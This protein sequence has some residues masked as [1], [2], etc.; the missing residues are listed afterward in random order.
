MK[1]FH[2]LAINPG[3]TSTKVA[4]FKND[5]CLFEFK[6]NH[7][8]QEL[9][10]YDSIWEQYNFR[11]EAISKAL[12]EQNGFS[13]DQLDA[14]VGRGGLINPVTGGT[15]RVNQAM[16]DDARAGVQGQ[17]ASNLGCGIA[18]DM[19]LEHNIPA[20][21]VDPPVVDDFEPL[22]RISGHKEFTR[23][24]TMHALN[25]FATARKYAKDINKKLTDLN[26]IVV[27]MGGGITVAAVKKGKAINANNALYEGPFSPERS[28]SVPMFKLL[29][30]AF[31]EFEKGTS[32]PEM[33]KMLVGRGGLVS[34][35]NTNDAI[36]VENKA[37]EKIPEYE[38]IYQA[39]AYQVAEEV[40]KRAT[41]LCGKADAILLTG[42]LAYSK[43]LVEWITE[44]TEF[45]APIKTYPGEAELESLAQGA[46]RILKGEEKALEYPD[47]RI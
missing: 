43:P 11:K 36:L 34:Y 20:F 5:E 21:I 32:L 4:V 19:G 9:E 45:I 29:D 6:L 39:I 3:S 26:L 30:R 22:A 15:Y 12:S 41:N 31:N 16:M 47:R 18:F 14:I 33:K 8:P 13:A 1:N 40:G 25:V 17:H 28:G 35:F 24:S 44:R 38:L 2:V 27:H 10:K 23:V 7:S 42:G 46:L 37:L